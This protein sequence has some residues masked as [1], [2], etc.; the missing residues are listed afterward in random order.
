MPAI[1]GIAM[2]CPYCNSDKPLRTTKTIQKDRGLVVRYH[3]CIACGE[4]SSSFQYLK[5]RVSTI[6]FP[7]YRNQLALSAKKV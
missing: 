2:T 1:Y 5:V 3:K 7:T 4:T 6:N